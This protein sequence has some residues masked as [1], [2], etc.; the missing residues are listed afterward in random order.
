VSTYSANDGLPW[1]LAQK[2]PHTRSTNRHPSYKI[3]IRISTSGGS[4]RRQLKAIFYKSSY[5]NLRLH[6]STKSGNF[7]NSRTPK[8]QHIGHTT[9]Q[10]TAMP[11]NIIKM[12]RRRYPTRTTV[13]ILNHFFQ[14]TASFPYHFR[15]FLPGISSGLL[16]ETS[17]QHSRPRDVSATTRAHYKTT[18]PKI[19]TY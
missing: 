3:S 14:K 4:K 7:H 5:Y 19:V 16:S 9:K 6:S 8:A 15:S 18:R 13:S 17:L 12:K 11:G 1:S 10:T 2:L